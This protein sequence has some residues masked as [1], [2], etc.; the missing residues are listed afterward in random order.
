MEMVSGCKVW[1]CL[2]N[3]IWKRMAEICML[4]ALL[5]SLYDKAAM[6][7]EFVPEI[8]REAAY[9]NNMHTF[10]D[11]VVEIRYFN[12]KIAEVLKR[13]KLAGMG[14]N[15]RKDIDVHVREAEAVVPAPVSDVK[16]TDEVY[17]SSGTK[18][19][20]DVVE[21]AG[22]TSTDVEEAPHVPVWNVT[23][24]G[25][26]GTPEVKNLSFEGETFSL[27]SVSVPTRLGKVFDGWYTDVSCTVP[28]AKGSVPETEIILYAGWRELDGVICNDNGY[29][30]DFSNLELLMTDGLLMLPRQEMCRGIMA[31]AFAGIEE[32][33]FEIFVPA[34]IEYIEPGTFELFSNL[35]Y[36]EVEGSNPVYYSQNGVL[37]HRDG[38]IIAM[39]QGW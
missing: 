9:V 3:I 16:S 39:P 2:P 14:E 17:I 22:Q 32:N 28:Y 19:A 33:I 36:I 27:D 4:V 21:D 5:W 25:N 37:Y 18:V 34:N 30:T 20:E 29:I 6:Q 8:K 35:M 12:Q 23:L 11:S 38:R 10:T 7:I 31:S 15:H 13:Q 24:Y 26:G 1:E